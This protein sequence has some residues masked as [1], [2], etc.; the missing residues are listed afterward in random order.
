MSTT[1]DRFQHF[2]QAGRWQGLP[3]RAEDA[4]DGPRFERITTGTTDSDVAD[5]A[6][7]ILM[8]G[9]PNFGMM[10]G[11]PTNVLLVGHLSDPSRQLTLIDAG[12]EDGY[13]VL[14]TALASEG[15]EP[16][17]IRQI[18]LTHCHPDHI[19]G[20]RAI[21][22]Q[23]GATVFA[24]PLERAQIERFGNGVEIDRWIENDEQ[25]AGDGFALDSIFTPGHSPGHYCLVE[26]SSRVLIAGDMISGFGSV[27]IF[28]PNGSM[29]AY[30][31][32]LRTMLAIHEETPFALVCP[33]HG[34]VIS[35]AGAKIR[36][37][38]EHRLTREADVLA[39]VLAGHAGIDDLLPAIY[40]DVQA[41]LS[42]AA[43]STLQAHLDK[44]VDDGEL[45]V[46]GER[47]VSANQ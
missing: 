6:V 18:V 36:E 46:D 7:D 26:Q 28:P 11:Q 37:Y 5:A 3:L 25:V 1:D 45:R 12:A 20:A 14:V 30:I 34:P 32:S 10:A 43:R 15:I 21:R 27:G 9:V 13:D 35:D 41:H 31:E 22:E 33:G 16:G 2:H 17:R 42:F 23:T 47:Y 29:A 38:I 24:H 19:G 8:L 39:A 4:T 40:P 44:L